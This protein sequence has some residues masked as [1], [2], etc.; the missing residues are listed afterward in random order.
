[1]TDAPFKLVLVLGGGNA[2]GGYQ[3]G[4][5]QALHERGLEPE[6][7]VGTSSGAINGA[8]IAGNAPGDR[9]ARLREYW[10]PA[11]GPVDEAWAMFPDETTR[12][13][14]AVMATLGV[15]RPGIFG[16]VGP[17]GSWW[18]P[19]P[20]AAAPSLF[21]AKQL[22]ATLARFVDF[23]R[24]NTGFPHY[25]ATAVDL[26][27]GGDV[28]FDTLLERVTAEHIRA[29]AALLP[30]FAPVEIGGRAYADGGLSA[31]LPLD[32]V[33]GAPPA[34]PTLCVAVDL[35]PVAEGRPRSLGESVA[36][37]QD[38]IFAAQSRRTI[39]R[40]RAVYALDPRANSVS[41][42]LVRLAYSD[43]DREVAGKAM[44]FSPESVRYRW[45]CGYRDASTMFDRIADGTIRIG[46]EGLTVTEM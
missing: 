37:A 25:T 8:L 44:D 24:L 4:V 21:D 1:M 30:T 15:G 32:P 23:E 39:E 2:L 9:I 12:R 10:Q 29:S 28:V 26:E 6:W 3:G 13:S 5:Y 45:D 34:Q 42:A 22:S 40:C 7:V 33:L 36:R 20:A 31:N 38:L 16:P 11:T 41:L 43:Q 14:A 19:D 17:L 35:M 27:T 46:A 18:D